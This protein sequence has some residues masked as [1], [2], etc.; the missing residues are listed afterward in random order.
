MSEK[1][2]QT[3]IATPEETRGIGTDLATAAV[4]GISTGAGA[5]LTQAALDKIK[6]KKK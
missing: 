5:V 6:P 4:A 1:N 3:K 2:Q